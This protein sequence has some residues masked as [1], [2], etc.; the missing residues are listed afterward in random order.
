[1][2]TE[3][4]PK[5]AGEGDDSSTATTT[6]APKEEAKKK[7]QPISAWSTKKVTYTL[8][9]ANMC[10]GLLLILIGILIFVSGMVSVTF[11]T[12][13]VLR[14]MFFQGCFLVLSLASH[15]L[16][17]LVFLPCICA[18]SFLPACHLTVSLLDLLQVT[19][20]AYIVFFGLLILCLECNISNL[21]PK[22]RRN[23]GFMFSFIGRTVFLLFCATM[24][25]A[26]AVWLGYLIGAI[27]CCE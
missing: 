4:R 15:S 5:F 13:C 25:F 16:P 20:A 3:E 14:G 7:R 22:F 6:A 8:R 23:F 19:V 2:S 21:A 26:L 24:C 9:V 10:N 12:V 17:S 1:M 27:T 11:T 18:Y